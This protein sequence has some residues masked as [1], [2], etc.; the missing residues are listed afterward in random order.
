[1]A[2]PVEEDPVS[3]NWLPDFVPHMCESDPVTKLRLPQMAFSELL[4]L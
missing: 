2:D 1:M 3:A 4:M